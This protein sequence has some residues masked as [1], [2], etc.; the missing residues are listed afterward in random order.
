MSD[1]ETYLGK[2]ISKYKDCIIKDAMFYCIE[3]GKRF[4]PNIIFSILKGFNIPE[5]KGYPCAAGLE[6]I[7][8]YSLIHDDLPCMDNDDLR[9]GKPSCHKQFGEDVALLA[10]DTFLTHAFS[11]ITDT[12]EYDGE[13]KS[14][15]ISELASLSG[16]NGMIYGQLLDVKEQNITKEKINEV[17]ENKTGGLFKYSCLAAMYIAGNNDYKYFEELGRKIG[18]LFQYQD[19]LFDAIKTEKETGKSNSDKDNNKFTALNLFKNTDEMKEY[20]DNLFKELYEYLNKAPFDATELRNLLY[21]M[22]SR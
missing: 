15:L 11:C 16:L 13:L 17:H 21:S 10:G 12:N 8:A 18:I 9:R 7:Q 4:R 19:D 5:E 14:I 2:E 3:G 22:K 20:I 6:F 1:F